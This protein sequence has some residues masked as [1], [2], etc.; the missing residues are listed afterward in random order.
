VVTHY[1]LKTMS[2]GFDETLPAAQ[3][4]EE[5][6]IGALYEEFQPRLLKY[7]LYRSP[8]AAEDVA[9]EVWIKVARGLPGFAGD[10]IEFRAWLFTI[11]RHALIDWRRHEQRRPEQPAE[12]LDLVGII[13]PVDT[14]E[15]A[16]EA[17]ST[18]A[19]LRTIALLPPDQADVVL[20]RVVAGLDAAH[21][22][23]IMGKRPGTIRVL[24][25]RALQRLVIALGATR[26]LD[27]GVTR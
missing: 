13:D 8:Q 20:L 21:V 22:G 7:L 3:A 4:A 15:S 17:F 12:P 18:A 25:H 1:I 23:R 10:E 27:E 5:W 2:P 16:L 24:Q 26:E 9:S 11:A 6:A 14:E 19:V